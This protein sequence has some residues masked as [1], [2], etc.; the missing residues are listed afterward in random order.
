MLPLHQVQSYINQYGVT[1]HSRHESLG[2]KSSTGGNVASNPTSTWIDSGAFLS[3]TGRAKHH[4]NT[5]LPQG[6]PLIC[7]EHIQG[8][9][10]MMVAYPNH[11][12]RSRQ[13]PKLHHR[14]FVTYS[15]EPIPGRLPPGYGGSSRQL[16]LL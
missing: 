15:T 7:R 13:F 4:M 10:M 1:Y 6:L 8:L 14:D 16:L 9:T 5:W 3:L 2:R 12:I 11:Q